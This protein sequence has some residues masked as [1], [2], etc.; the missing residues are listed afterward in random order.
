MF[1][2]FLLQ[3]TSADHIF[4]CIFFL[5]ALRV[6]LFYKVMSA[7]SSDENGKCASTQESLSSG[8]ANK[9]GTDQSAQS[10]QHF[11]MSLLET[12]HV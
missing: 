12:Y 4:G 1:G 7:K 6:S 3:T 9:K 2:N 8:F 11:V 10:A 5:G